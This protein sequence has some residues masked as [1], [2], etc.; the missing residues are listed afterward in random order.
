MSEAF[1]IGCNVKVSGSWDAGLNGLIGTVV[2]PISGAIGRYAEH[3]GYVSVTFD[4]PVCPG[5]YV[6]PS[7]ELERG[8]SE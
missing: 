7:K 6:F 5:T 1:P 4:S 2:E 8:A 3:L